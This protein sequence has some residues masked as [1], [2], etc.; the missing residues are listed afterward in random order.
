[1]LPTPYQNYIAMS[2]YSRWRDDLKR[3][4]TWSEVVDRYTA[5]FK[6]KFR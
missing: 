4:E 2:R 5:F 1:M 6:K 3:R